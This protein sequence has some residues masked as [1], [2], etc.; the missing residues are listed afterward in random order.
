MEE[1]FLLNLFNGM[2]SKATFSIF[3]DKQSSG[4]EFLY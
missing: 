1:V 3:L 4:K 2:T